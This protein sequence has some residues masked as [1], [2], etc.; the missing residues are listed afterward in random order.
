MGMLT[1]CGY[2]DSRN[3]ILGHW[4]KLSSGFHAT[5][6]LSISRRVIYDLKKLKLLSQEQNRLVIN[7][8]YLLG[9][10]VAK[11]VVRLLSTAALWVRI[12][13]LLKNTK[14]GDISKGVANTL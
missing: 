6:P 7:I 10:W 8:M 2:V 1:I 5:L 9:R 4:I 14:I 12:Q 11:L 3:I 13:I